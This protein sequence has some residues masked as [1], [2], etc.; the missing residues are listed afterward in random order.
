MPESRTNPRPGLLSMESLGLLEAAV[1]SL[2]KDLIPLG[3]HRMPFV[4][5]V[6]GNLEQVLCEKSRSRETGGDRNNWKQSQEGAGCSRA[7]EVFAG[8]SG[9]EFAGTHPALSVQV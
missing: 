9:A 3:I 2:R 7:M 5:N 1:Q 6:C 4:N 8:R